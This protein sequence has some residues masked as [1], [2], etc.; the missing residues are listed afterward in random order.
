V[1][2]NQFITILTA[3][4]KQNDKD[5]EH[6]NT[7]CEIYGATDLAMYDNSYLVNLLLKQLQ[8]MFP[9]NTQGDC[10]I[11]RFMYTFDFGRREKSKFKDAGHLWDYLLVNNTPIYPIDWSMLENMDNKRFF[12]E[13]DRALFSDI[14]FPKAV[15]KS[16]LTPEERK[17]QIGLLDEAGHW[18]LTFKVVESKE[19]TN[20][21]VEKI[22][23]DFV[24]ELTSKFSGY[25]ISGVSL[26]ELAIHQV[27]CILLYHP[28]PTIPTSNQLE[29]DTT[30]KAV[31]NKLISKK[32]LAKKNDKTH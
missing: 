30:W 16:E 12:K 31:K 20:E 15:F 11:E 7:L 5:V 29:F 19:I 1:N 32:Q 17:K 18:P 14:D 26:F 9:V 13:G 3:L 4:Q 22:A 2:K 10:E 8:E 6:H 23:F 25:G 21:Y 24:N 27:E 28:I